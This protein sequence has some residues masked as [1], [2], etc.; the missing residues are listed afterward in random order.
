MILHVRYHEQDATAIYGFTGKRYR[1]SGDLDSYAV[2]GMV[3]ARLNVLATNI[4]VVLSNEDKNGELYIDDT[5]AYL[6]MCAHSAHSAHAMCMPLTG[7]L[8]KKMSRQMSRATQ[9]KIEWDQ[10]ACKIEKAIQKHRGEHPIDLRDFFNVATHR[11][12]RSA[13]KANVDFNPR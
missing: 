6:C 1:Y 3:C 9:G 8:F 11:L 13:I 10:A 12:T 2:R 4:A 5:F 7:T